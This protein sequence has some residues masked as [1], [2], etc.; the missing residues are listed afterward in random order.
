[1]N[2]VQSSVFKRHA[3]PSLP[4]L[5]LPPE[6]KLTWEKLQHLSCSLSLSLSPCLR[7]LFSYLCSVWVLLDWF[8]CECKVPVTGGEIIQPIVTVCSKCGIRDG[9]GTSSPTKFMPLLE[10]AKKRE[11]ENGQKKEWN[12][13]IRVWHPPIHLLRTWSL[14][15][16]EDEFKRPCHI[17][18]IETI[19]WTTIAAVYF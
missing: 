2:S 12:R 19:S 14:C 1:M 9:W 7:A 3:P 16:L 6:E 13:G 15:S 11:K 5:W 10:G 17:D 8:I 4:F 18:A